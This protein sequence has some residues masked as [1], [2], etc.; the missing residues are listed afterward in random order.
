MARRPPAPPQ[1]AMLTPEQMRQG[2][3]RLERRI[4]EVE[5]FDPESIQTR[6]DTSKGEAFAASVK[7]ALEQT[8]GHD[9]VEF[10]RYQGAA[11]F[12]WPLNLMPS[13]AH[14]RNSGELSGH[15]AFQEHVVFGHSRAA[16]ALLG[17][18][19]PQFFGLAPHF[20]D[21]AGPTEKTRYFFNR[22][23]VI[24]MGRT[25]RCIPA[26]VQPVSKTNYGTPVKGLQSLGPILGT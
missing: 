24:H 6:D 7:G 14:P 19:Q 21:R 15:R 22:A 1:Q 2:I 11:S 13:N 20:L 16:P 5:A 23:P 17:S 3:Q 26:G 18:Q 9:T 25:E 10:Q 12:H 4:A 8:F